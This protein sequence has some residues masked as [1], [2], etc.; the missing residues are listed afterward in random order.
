M[1]Y[2]YSRS[3]YM[4]FQGLKDDEYEWWPNEG[5]LEWVRFMGFYPC[6]A[7]VCFEVIHEFSYVMMMYVLIMFMTYAFHYLHYDARTW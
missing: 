5:Y 6:I 3:F 1:N 2:G 7:Q 4:S